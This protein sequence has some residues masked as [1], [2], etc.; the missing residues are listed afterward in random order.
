MRPRGNFRAADEPSVDS[1]GGPLDLQVKE[2][3]RD[4]VPRPETRHRL[5]AGQ[6]HVPGCDPGTCP[7]LVPGPVLHV[8]GQVPVPGV[9]DADCGNHGL[10]A[11]LV[12]TYGPHAQER[13]EGSSFQQLRAGN[14]CFIRSET[15]CRGAEGTRAGGPGPVRLTRFR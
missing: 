9:E 13:H 3:G 14:P 15:A 12:L 8:H 2:R 6:M 10:G 7:D 4:R 1:L 11:D 5:E